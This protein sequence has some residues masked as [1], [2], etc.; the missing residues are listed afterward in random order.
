VRTAS[1]NPVMGKRYG[2]DFPAI[3]VRDIVEAQRLLRAALGVNRLVAVAGP[4]YGDAKYVEIDSDFGH[5]ASG[6]EW[7]K[8]GPALKAFLASLEP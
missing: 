7:A 1:I 5:S 8:W 4:S 3:T 2:P 6:P